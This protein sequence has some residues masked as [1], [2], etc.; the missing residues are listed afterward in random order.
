MSDEVRPNHAQCLTSVGETED[1]PTGQH[2]PI[3]LF[4]VNIWGATFRFHLKLSVSAAT[5]LVVLRFLHGVRESL[6]EQKLY[7]LIQ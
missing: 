1:D 3:S 7:L 6:F 5:L 2:Y 4:Q